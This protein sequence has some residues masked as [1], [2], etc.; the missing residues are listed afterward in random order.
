VIVV[1]AE[2]SAVLAWLLGEARQQVVISELAAADRVVASTLT[3]VECA[4]ALARARMTGRLRDADELAALRLLN[5]AS[6]SWSVLDVSDRV[7]ER[8]C[9]AFPRE[10][11]R[12]LDALHLA[13][14][15]VFFEALGSLRVLSLDDRVRLNASAMGM[16]LAPATTA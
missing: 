4:R 11:V 9:G 10:P 15:S 14:A 8:A 6:A 1:Y 13:T 12:T 2:S 3:V 5:Q 16:S 7:A